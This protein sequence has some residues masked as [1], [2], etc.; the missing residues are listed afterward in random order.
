MK[1]ISLYHYPPLLFSPLSSDL[2][3]QVLPF[4]WY[5]LKSNSGNGF[6]IFIS[7]YPNNTS[8]FNGKNIKHYTIADYRRDFN[9]KYCDDVDVLMWGE[10]DSLIPKQTFEILDLLHTNN[11][12]QHI[13]TTLSWATSSWLF[14]L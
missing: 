12:N 4:F 11:K 7:F 5:F 10:S 8:D 6:D 9:D 3:F 1:P 13:L 2:R 14:L